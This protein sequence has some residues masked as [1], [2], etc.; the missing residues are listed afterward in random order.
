[1]TNVSEKAEQDWRT[2]RRYKFPEVKIREDGDHIQFSQRGWANQDHVVKLL[3]TV[4]LLWFIPTVLLFLLS[5]YWMAGMVYAVGSV[6]PW[7][8]V[9]GVGYLFLL[10]RTYVD[11]YPSE[12]TVK[13]ARQHMTLTFDQIRSIDVQQDGVGSNSVVIWHGPVALYTL[14][15][16]NYQTALSVRE[17]M[18]AAIAMLS[19]RAVAAPQPA[20][21]S[22]QE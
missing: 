11:I 5:P 22:F 10:R 19:S 1:M 20:R 14:S 15:S 2:F 4:G 3:I 6:T 12:L 18:A 13:N 16:T 17:G 8:L 7:M 9:F 21:R